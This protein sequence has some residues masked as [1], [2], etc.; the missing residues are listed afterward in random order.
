MRRIY[1]KYNH[2]I[3]LYNLHNVGNSEI[4]F[5]YTVIQIFNIKIKIWHNFTVKLHNVVFFTV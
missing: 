3:S 4:T 2:Y 5:N 1:I